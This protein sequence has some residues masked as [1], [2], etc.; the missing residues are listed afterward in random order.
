[1]IPAAPTSSACLIRTRS[2]QATR[3]SGTAP[4]SWAAMTCAW[5]V[6][7]VSAPCSM[8]IQTKSSTLPKSSVT[9]G[10]LKVIATPSATKPPCRRS[11]NER[12]VQSRVIERL[13]GEI[14]ARADV[15]VDVGAGPAATGERDGGV[16]RLLPADGAEAVGEAADV[17]SEDHV[18][19]ADQRVIGRGRLLLQHVQAGAGDP[20]VVEGADERLLVDDAAAGGVDQDRGRLHQAQ[21]ALPDQVAGTAGERDVDR[22]EVGPGQQLVERDAARVVTVEQVGGDERVVGEQRHLEAAQTGGERAGGVAEAE[23]ADGLAAQVA[24]GQGVLAVPGAG[25][26]QAVMDRDLADEREPEANDVLGEALAGGVRGVGDHDPARG[27]GEDGDVV[28]AAAGA[29]D[30]AAAGEDVEVVGGE[31]AAEEPDHVGVVGVGGE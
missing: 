13:P 2:F 28:H 30:G 26:N 8:S 20:A 10:S 17:G 31:A 4:A 24:V 22:E 5:T 6:S 1:M 3:T 23:Q 25:A 21:L 7:I 18:G 9:V 29:D 19:A 27:G 11:R 12:P 14:P 15:G 16:H